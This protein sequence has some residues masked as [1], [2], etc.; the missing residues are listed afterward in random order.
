MPDKK[1]PADSR[2]TPV[3]VI[4]N[5]IRRPLRL[6]LTAGESKDKNI[7]GLPELVNEQVGL[8]LK[9]N[10]TGQRPEWVALKHQFEH[11]NDLAAADRRVRLLAAV[12]ILDRLGVRE[13]PPK[14][15]ASVKSI[16]RGDSLKIQWDSSVQYLKGVGPHRARR[17]EE[18]G[19]R[20]AE[21]L[22]FYIPWRYDDRSRIVPVGELTP[23]SESTIA[24]VVQATR[25]MI[26]SRRKFKIFEA[27]IGD[28]TGSVTVKWFNQPYLQK[29]IENGKRIMVS[30]KLKVSR[31]R[32]GAPEIE[33]PIFEILDEDEPT[34]GLNT[35]RIVP[36]Y[37]E[38]SGWTNR[39]LRSLIHALLENGLPGLPEILP[40]RT[41]AG[42][43]L[44]PIGDAFREIHFP[45]KGTSLEALNEG[46]TRAHHRLVFDEFLLLQLGI[47]LKRREAVHEADGTAFKTE[48]PLLGRFLEALPFSLTGEQ[49][50]VLDEIKRDMG[51]SRP[52]NRLL[53]GDVGC[54]K[55]VVATASMIIA[56]DN[57]FQSALMAP[58]EILAEQHYT[59][60]SNWLK[61]LGLRCEVLTSGRG[62]TEIREV[63]RAV[64]AGE[65]AIV[66]G[67]HALIQNDVRF[68]KLGMV[69][70]DEQHKFG[71]LQRSVLRKKG[72]HPDVLVMTA[73]PI[74][75]TLALTVHGDL[76]LSVIRELPKG[77]SGI[78][79][80]YFSGVQRAKAYALVA[81]EVARG[82]QAYVVYPLV[83]ESEKLDL[84]S[85]VEMAG[86]F[87][88]EVFPTLRVGLLHGQMKSE[89]KEKT[90]A[91]FKSGDIQIL[92]STTV[93]EVGIDVSNATVMVVENAERFGLSQLHQLRG[94]VGRG[95]EKSFCVLISGH[96][97]S[98]DARK[99][100]KVMVSHSDG[101]VIAEEDLLIRGP[102][103]FFG[104]R[105][106]GLPEF[107]VA[108]I[109]RD[110]ALLE[111]AREE[112]ARILE[113]DPGLSSPEN[114]ELR[115]ALLRKWGD[116]LELFT[117]S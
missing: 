41:L 38:R 68:R 103:E 59:T 32:G 61:P 116:R 101:F 65:V 90:M 39:Q 87:Q 102:G 46:R 23:G 55:T 106:S 54:G 75:R 86:R 113:G 17:F 110:G 4:I 80:M 24:G 56:A 14:T 34:E 42:H 89:E 18:I 94:R 88:K 29:V 105:Q 5:R 117:V 15:V 108:N 112:A 111:T 6:A 115:K 96:A 43:S 28:N 37:H 50:R 12:E 16:Y 21:D 100:L 92:V 48:G 71:V 72:Y 82:R 33:N 69:V 70:V 73:T 66:I 2:E 78:D 104:T 9:H 25:L 114:A 74:P 45:E 44:I 58:T 60:F 3:D 76:D 22:L 98:Q 19:I 10:L 64:E 51:R 49:T 67:T 53:Q 85:A 26:T 107:R 57:G 47:G 81:R 13:F 84:Q 91:A 20:T 52:M 1:S 40:Q 27:V 35:G 62:K 93:I 77:R 109:L 7:Q 11:F 8:A 99:R 31:Y 95:P 79:T 83:E 97:V 63:L 36:V 30:G